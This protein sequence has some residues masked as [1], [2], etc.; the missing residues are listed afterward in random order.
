MTSPELHPLVVVLNSTKV[1]EFHRDRPLT[2]NQLIDLKNTE[3]KLC[4]GIYLGEQFI[5]DPSESDKA[6]FMSHQL[7]L[8]LENDND[9]VIAISCAYLAINYPE[10]KQV[11]ASSVDGQIAIQ[12]INDEIF[13]ESTPLTF[14]PRKDI[15]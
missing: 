3:A 12:L 2:E 4:S 15:S 9:T 8:A 7:I 5:S 1:L 13:I 11:R 6:L 14:T 10:L